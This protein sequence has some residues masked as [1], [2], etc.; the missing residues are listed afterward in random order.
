MADSYSNSETE[1]E[2][3]FSALDF[4]SIVHEAEAWRVLPGES[5]QKKAKSTPKVMA[6]YSKDLHAIVLMDKYITKCL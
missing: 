1:S 4:D 3:S 2:R 6:V 5:V